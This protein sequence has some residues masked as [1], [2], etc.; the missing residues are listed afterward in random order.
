MITNLVLQKVPEGDGQ[1]MKRDYFGAQLSQSLEF[2]LWSVGAAAER[3]NQNS[4]LHALLL[5]LAQVF[6]D[7]TAHHSVSPDV[8]HEY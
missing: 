6:N 3:I 2:F 7:L 1:R 5:F 4:D 8:D